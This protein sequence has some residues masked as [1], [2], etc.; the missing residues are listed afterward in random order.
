MMKTKVDAK[1]EKFLTFL[2]AIESE[3]SSIIPTSSSKKLDSA[4]YTPHASRSTTAFPADM[5][6]ANSRKSKA[7]EPQA[8]HRSS[9][10]CKDDPREFRG[11][12]SFS[13]VHTRLF[14]LIDD[15]ETSEM[16]LTNSY[17]FSDSMGEGLERHQSEWEERTKSMKTRVIKD[18]AKLAKQ[19]RKE[20]QER[21][22]L[23]SSALV[24]SEDS[25]STA[26]ERKENEGQ[27]TKVLQSE[28]KRRKNT[29]FLLRKKGQVACAI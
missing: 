28:S 21:D 1:Y 7:L 13:T 17:R 22:K 5:H 26:R 10:R 29:W 20:K 11:S 6:Q 24:V 15:D 19:Q 16:I 18:R 3:E 23:P 4:Q 8:P 14:E 2:R 12:I 25:N 9:L 27:E